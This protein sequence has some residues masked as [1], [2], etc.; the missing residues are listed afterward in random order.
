M[1]RPESPLPTSTAAVLL[2]S[3]VG[4]PL[5]S[6]DTDAQAAGS[7]LAGGGEGDTGGPGPSEGS[8]AAGTLSQLLRVL[9]DE[10]EDAS[11]AAVANEQSTAVEAFKEGGPVGVAGPL[12]A[13]LEPQ[14]LSPVATQPAPAKAD[15]YRP[16]DQ[17]LPTSPRQAQLATK[18]ALKDSAASGS[19]GNSAE[20]TAPKDAPESKD[21]P[22]KPLKNT[23]AGSRLIKNAPSRSTATVRQLAD[24]LNIGLKV[25]KRWQREGRRRGQ[26][27]QRMVQ[28]GVVDGRVVVDYLSGCWGRR[29]SS[30][31]N[32]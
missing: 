6:D 26:G 4:V 10:A 9:T 1:S 3:S 31:V 29:R 20:G 13:L 5:L 17:A 18:E 27:S 30:V 2:S 28:A 8:G 24:A 15:R 22:T 25:H 14:D 7:F 21:A 12:T 32:R 16:D 19:K 23:A 11:K